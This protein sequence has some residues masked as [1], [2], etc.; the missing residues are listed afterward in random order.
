[1]KGKITLRSV[2]CTFLCLWALWGTPATAQPLWEVVSH[3]LEYRI[4]NAG[5]PFMGTFD[6]LDLFVRL[7]TA[8]VPE[9]N[10]MATVP[11]LSIQTSQES[12]SQ[13]LM[14]PS[15][16]DAEQHPT[17]TINS[18]KMQYLGSGQWQADFAVTI[19]GVTKTLPAQRFRLDPKV[20]A[21]QPVNLAFELRRKDFG[22]GSKA[23]PGLGNK[24]QVKVDLMLKPVFEGVY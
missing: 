24:V 16:F 15:F 5:V 4:H 17:M 7:D 9:S 6:S 22:I 2:G 3:K 14:R 18:R 8:V 11:V 12:M 13:H 20:Q 10:I 19:K 21:P 23:Y 1:M